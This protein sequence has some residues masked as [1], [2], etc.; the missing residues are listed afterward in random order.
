MDI[1][2]VMASALNFTLDLRRQ[3]D[4]KWGSKREDGT[5]SGMMGS[6]VY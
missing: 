5:W 4:G 1:A 2:R 3:P 6:L